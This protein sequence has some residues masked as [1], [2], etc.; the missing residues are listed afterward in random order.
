MFVLSLMLLAAAGIVWH[1]A[2]WA[3][4]AELTAYLIASLAAGI[5]AT[6]NAKASP[7]MILLM[8][9]V[10]ATIHLTWGSSFLLRML[11][12]MGTGAE[13]ET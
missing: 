8:P 7:L 9:P 10:F 3:L 5:Q 4:L 12:K 2:G 6:Y 13:I 11:K 1:G